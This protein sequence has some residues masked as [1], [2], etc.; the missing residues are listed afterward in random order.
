MSTSWLSSF[1]KSQFSHTSIQRTV[2]YLVT[3]TNATSFVYLLTIS[4]EKKK[5]VI[6]DSFLTCTVSF[7][8]Q[9]SNTQRQKTRSPFC[10]ADRKNNL[11]FITSRFKYWLVPCKSSA[12]K[13]E[14]LGFDLSDWYTV[15][16]FNC[17][18]GFI[19]Y[20]KISVGYCQMADYQSLCNSTYRSVYTYKNIIE[21]DLKLLMPNM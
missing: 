20:K 1:L 6:K 3:Y 2:V 11:A 19:W 8:S 7:Q 9:A 4:H 15:I 10:Q 5:L 17:K 12:L 16:M 21:L 14:S 18:K 13:W